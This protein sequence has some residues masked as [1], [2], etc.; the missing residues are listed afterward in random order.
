MK[1]NNFSNIEHLVNLIWPY[2]TNAYESHTPILELHAVSYD[3][4]ALPMQISLSDLDKVHY[5]IR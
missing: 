5:H 3:C 4:V 2:Q 1:P